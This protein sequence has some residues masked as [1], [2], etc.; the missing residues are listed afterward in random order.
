M[1]PQSSFQPL[2]VK[3][4]KFDLCVEGG[5]KESFLNISQ[6]AFKAIVCRRNK[7]ELRYI[8]HHKNQRASHELSH[9]RHRAN[10]S[11]ELCF[12]R[13]CSS[14]QRKSGPCSRWP[15][16][17]GHT[18]VPSGHGYQGEGSWA[19]FC[20]VLLLIAQLCMPIVYWVLKSLKS[21]QICKTHVGHCPDHWLT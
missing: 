12:D 7:I 6:L 11:I 5:R 13:G 4:L 21:L 14:K 20:E 19:V 18:F 3:S 8:V 1:S 17:G 2:G 10:G 9:V 16:R 15:T